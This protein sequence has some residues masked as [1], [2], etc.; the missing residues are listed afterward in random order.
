AAIMVDNGGTGTTAD[1]AA[2]AA[3]KLVAGTITTGNDMKLLQKAQDGTNVDPGT[4]P[5]AYF[6]AAS[7]Q[8]PGL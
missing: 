3:A 8:I 7:G 6:A 1:K 5:Y 4:N 2:A